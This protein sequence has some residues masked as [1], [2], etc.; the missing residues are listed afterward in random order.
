MN[1]GISATTMLLG[2]LECRVRITA[3]I[4]KAAAS[5]E[6]SSEEIR[7]YGISHWR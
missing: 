7:K 6:Q 5:N 2:Q 3:N 4:I 1:V